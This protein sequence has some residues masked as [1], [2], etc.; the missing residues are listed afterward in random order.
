MYALTREID[1]HEVPTT[2]GRADPQN[3]EEKSMIERRDEGGKRY[4]QKKE[5]PSQI[6]EKR[7]IEE[8]MVTIERE[9]RNAKSL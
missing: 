4:A 7:G 3:E 2:N 5:A 1:A 9:V 6:E 8:L